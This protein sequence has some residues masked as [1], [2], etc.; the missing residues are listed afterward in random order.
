MKYDNLFLFAI[1][2]TL[3]TGHFNQYFIENSKNIYLFLMPLSI[4]KPLV[5]LTHYNNGK[6]IEEKIFFS[7]KGNNKFLRFLFI[8][9]YYIYSVLFI[10]PRDTFIFATTPQYCFF[11]NIFKILKNIK[12]VYQI[13]DY[14]PNQKG[15]MRI[16]QH[17]V[18]YFSKHLR[19]VIYNSP[20]IKNKLYCKNIS[21]GFIRETCGWGIENKI[22]SK[23]IKMNIL[24]FVGVVREGQG[25]ELIFEVLK[26]N[27]DLKLEIIGDG[28]YLGS[29]KLLALKL[30][31]D[32][33][34]R[35]WGLVKS[36]GKIQKIVKHWAIGIAP[37]NPDTNNMSFYGE[38]SKT[39]FYLEY[40]IPVIMTK[41][42]YMKDE[43]LKY[44]A[45]EIIDY[46][47]KSLLTKISKILNDYHSYIKGVNMLVSKYEYKSLYN[48]KFRFLLNS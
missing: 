25:I 12:I 14:Y 20:A 30:K 19:Y 22:I 23:E 39:K 42:T 9:L 10:I 48:N 5:T 7:Y 17:L 27:K 46:N 47:Q 16:Y 1:P 2:S 24:G 29:L 35:F 13:N 31:I 26:N 40:K 21:K 32:G 18:H 38:P 36:E 41:I 45:G 43:L 11:S 37:Y 34:V 28:P 15:L 4:Q 6:K 44:H 3:S 8:Y 33:R